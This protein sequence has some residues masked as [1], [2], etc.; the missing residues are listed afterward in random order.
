MYNP[1]DRARTF[2]KK[3]TAFFDTKKEHRELMDNSITELAGQYEKLKLTKKDIAERIAFAEKELLS[4]ENDDV[5][6]V[7]HIE[8]AAL[9]HYQKSQIMPEDYKAWKKEDGI[10]GLQDM[11]EFDEAKERRSPKHGF[12]IPPEYPSLIEHDQNVASRKDISN[13][14]VTAKSDEDTAD[15]KN[16]FVAGS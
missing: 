5:R 7:I 4:A 8:L 3:S 14:Q 1:F 12:P 15:R 16:P 11:P 9:R 2:L 10:A 13:V 6:S